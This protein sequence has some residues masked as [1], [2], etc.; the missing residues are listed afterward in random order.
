MSSSAALVFPAVQ[1]DQVPAGSRP[2]LDKVKKA[3]GFIP[4]LFA[5]FPGTA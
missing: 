1:D 3:F 4:N 5:S 2:L